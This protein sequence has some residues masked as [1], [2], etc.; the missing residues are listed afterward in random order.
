[1]LCLSMGGRTSVCF[2]H[3]VLAVYCE[4]T[5]HIRCPSRVEIDHIIDNVHI[6][7]FQSYDG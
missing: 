2:V 3:Y 4:P 1:M 7:E 6:R 5:V